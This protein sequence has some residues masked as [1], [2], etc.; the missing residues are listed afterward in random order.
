MALRSSASTRD[1][2]KILP[3]HKSWEVRSSR[4]MPRAPPNNMTRRGTVRR[5]ADLGDRRRAMCVD[6]SKRRS[7][8][9]R[10]GATP[11]GI[12]GSQVQR[13]AAC[14]SH[15]CA[16]PHGRFAR[17]G[18]ASWRRSCWIR[19]ILKLGAMALPRRICPAG[20]SPRHKIRLEGAGMASVADACVRRNILSTGTTSGAAPP[21]NRS[22]R[23]RNLGTGG[24]CSGTRRGRRAARCDAGRDA[25]AGVDL[26]SAETDALDPSARWPRTRPCPTSRLAVGA[27]R[28]L[29]QPL[30]PSGANLLNTCKAES[31][32]SRTS[33]RSLPR[34][35]HAA[36]RARRRWMARSTAYAIRE[37]A[38][39]VRWRSRQSV[40]YFNAETNGGVNSP[41]Q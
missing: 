28:R 41:S 11:P 39:N 27:I 24:E 6:R 36:G 17:S 10:G 16:T 34:L 38:L 32:S 15:C 14:R 4:S 8:F 35:R 19:G 18:A 33:R 22:A 3:W 9:A 30:L 21:R 2:L 37:Q 1:A 7:G 5:I 31:A 25:P 29:L 12:D 13:P 26:V 23:A 20:R 40:R